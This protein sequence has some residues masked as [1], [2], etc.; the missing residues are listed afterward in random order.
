MTDQGQE[1]DQ[2]SKGESLSAELWRM[3]T[4]EIKPHFVEEAEF[5]QKY[6]E[7]AGYD[8]NYIGRV[9]SDH[10]LLEELVWGKDVESI[11]RF[12]KVLS[13]H[14][15]YKQAFFAER[16]RQIVEADGLPTEVSAA[17]QHS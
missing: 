17:G 8:R 11:S 2:D 15:H 16:V 1:P 12:A 3:W 7:G 6:G 13:A 4:A 9:L 5:L 10:R 14:I